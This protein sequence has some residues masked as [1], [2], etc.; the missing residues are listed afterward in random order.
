MRVKV[1]RRRKE[2]TVSPS[3]NAFEPSTISP[4]VITGLDISGNPKYLGR[5]SPGTWNATNF[6]LV[7]LK[8]SPQSKN[9]SNAYAD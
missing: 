6:K 9:V 1:K 2:P 8:E 7:V 4:L 3:S 5:L